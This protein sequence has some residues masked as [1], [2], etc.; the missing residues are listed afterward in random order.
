MKTNQKPRAAPT[1]GLPNREKILS[2]FSRRDPVIAGIIRDYG[3][4]RLKSNKNY[5]VVLCKA[6]VS[7]QISTRAAETIFRRFLHIFDGKP[8]TPQRIFA[9]PESSLTNAG[10]SRQKAAYIK[11]LSR[12]FL[13]KTIRPHRLPYLSNED[14]ILQLTA[15]HGIGRWTAEMFLI[16][17]LN[18]LDV[19]PLGD[20]GFQTA[21]KKIYNM[22]RAPSAK[23]MKA[24][25]E[26]WHPYETIATWYAWRT[27]D[28]NI[29]AY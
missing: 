9:V 11:D 16:F 15:V 20:Q 21:V 25:G 8:P 13:D 22:K 26:K 5:F 4:F 23:T 2:H 28:E 10:L 19:L 12:R 27:L 7:Q 3:P 24:L 1:R 6:I 18:R 29:I 14:A 17:S